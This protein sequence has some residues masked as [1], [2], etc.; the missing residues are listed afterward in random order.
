MKTLYDFNP[1]V[2]ELNQIFRYN[3]WFSMSKYDLTH[4]LDENCRC[5]A[6]LFYIRGQLSLCRRYI[7]CIK[8]EKYR[9]E[10]EDYFLKPHKKGE[11]RFPRHRITRKEFIVHL[12]DSEGYLYIMRL[13]RELSYTPEDVAL[14]YRFVASLEYEWDFGRAIETLKALPVGK[15][16]WAWNY[17]RAFVSRGPFC[18]FPLKEIVE[19][20]DLNDKLEDPYG[21]I[22]KFLE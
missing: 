22:S 15:R 13:L 10:L 18:P 11:K 17:L 12:F 16:G 1:T 2:E 7:A 20:I 14:W 21:I 4:N 19:I 3:L 6:H 8:N 5:L 9:K